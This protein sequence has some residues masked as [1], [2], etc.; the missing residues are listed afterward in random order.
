[1]AQKNR[2]LAEKISRLRAAIKLK[3]HDKVPLVGN[4]GFWPVKYLHKYTMQEAFY[5]IDVMAESYEAVIARWSRWDALTTSVT[6]R[7][8]LLDALGSRRYVIPG[9]EISP[10][11]D[12]Q[13]PDQCFMEADEYDR[14]IQDPARFQAEVILPRVCARITTGSL[15]ET[16]K[17]IAKV[18][19]YTQQLQKKAG[20]FWDGWA[21]RYAISPLMR[22]VFLVPVDLIVD[23]FRGFNQGLVDIKLRPGKIVEASHAL[24]DSLI[25]GGMAGLPAGQDFP[26]LYNPQHVSPF[27]SPRDYDKV[28]WPFYKRMVDEF[29]GR[30]HTV[31][32]VFEGV[33]DQ[34]LERLQD[35]PAG[36]V[37]AH[38]EGTDL[39]KAKKYLSGKICIAGGMPNNILAKGSP[40][41]VTEQVKAVMKL[42]ADEPGFIMAADGG[43]NS[44]KPE[45][46]DAW[47][48]ALEQYGYL[49]GKLQ[50]EEPAADGPAAV[51]P[52][53]VQ[54]SLITPWEQVRDEFG[55]IKGDEE[56]IGRAWEELE[57]S[58]L[59]L[60][61]MILRA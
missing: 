61:G 29:T 39:A 43:L 22:N 12:Y 49:G 50:V 20:T 40:E 60:L 30:G 19:T 35:L 6:S 54:K 24:L 13:H 1:M 32:S 48:R 9:R 42:F 25:H 11:A 18:Y 58:A 17:A 33:Q 28:Y 53:A 52:Q 56:I 38:F 37:V 4:L 55:E 45:N 15:Y 36:K 47:M 23:S 27:I 8:P 59:G 21:E 26:V 7:A 57:Y 41:D 10:H 3:E 51:G 14:L 5:N 44:A 46:I 2:L 16:I 34:H 31:W